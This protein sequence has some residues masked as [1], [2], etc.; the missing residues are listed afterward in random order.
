MPVD[1]D[2]VD[3]ETVRAME[4][5]YVDD[6]ASELQN[7][8]TPLNAMMASIPMNVVETGKVDRA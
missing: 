7:L 4:R 6:P 3:V 2:D 1:N 5:R 8:T